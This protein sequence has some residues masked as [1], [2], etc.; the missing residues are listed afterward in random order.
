MKPLLLDVKSLLKDSIYIKEIHVNHLDDEFHFHNAYEIAL[1]LKSNGKRVIGDSIED[2]TD[3]DLVLMGPHLP[4]ISYTNNN[5]STEVHALV[6]YFHPDWLT[7][8]HLN[9]VDFARFRKLFDDMARGIKI[10][11]NT[12]KKV[13]K[14]ILK[15]KN[16][17]GLQRIIT[18]LE[19]LEIISHS[20]EYECLA[21][22]GYVNSFSQKDIKRMDQVYKYVKDHFTEDIMLEDI[23][24]IANM[25]P[26]AFC[27][28]FKIKTNKTFSNFVNEVRIGYACKLLFDENLSI[29]QI[30]FKCGFN[31]LT[32]FN[33][34][35][36]RFTKM[37]PSTYK[38]TFTS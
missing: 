23:A 12:K 26:T 21:S 17:K 37:V 36:K 1:I 6:V 8:T 38:A 25:T 27:K 29:S 10:L 22:P 7:D 32:N 24:S 2:F 33:K 30:C 20:T 16:C 11:G 28:F 35:F 4:H 14:R 3:N 31:N 9:S 34:N 5:D 18:I 15:L 19:I 13:T